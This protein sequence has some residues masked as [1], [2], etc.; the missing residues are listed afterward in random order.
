MSRIQPARILTYSLMTVVGLAAAC[1]LIMP[2]LPQL[3]L[4]TQATTNPNGG[5]PYHGTTTHPSP[6]PIPQDNRIVIPKLYVESPIVEGP[7]DKA[8][9]QGVWRRPG[10]STPPQ[11]S[12]TVLAGH[13]FTYHTGAVF[14]NLDKLQVGDTIIVYWDGIEYAYKVNHIKTVSPTEIA[15]ERPT[16][17]PTLTLYTCTPLWSN[18]YRLVIQAEPIPPAA[19]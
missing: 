19:Q 6:K 5:N 15:I 17:S 10:T 1:L 8:L 18:K 3:A 13:R 2:L 7:N 12:N 9:D 4:W 16:T 11:G 14:Y